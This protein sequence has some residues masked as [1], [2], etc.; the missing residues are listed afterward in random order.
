[1]VKKVVV[2]NKHKIRP[3]SSSRSSSTAHTKFI[4]GKYDRA[5]HYVKMRDTM[6][7]IRHENDSAGER[8]WQAA[9]NLFTVNKGLSDG[10]DTAFNKRPPNTLKSK[11]LMQSYIEEGTV[12]DHHLLHA[13]ITVRHGERCCHCGPACTGSRVKMFHRLESHR[14]QGGLRILL[15][16]DLLI[17]ILEI[18]YKYRVGFSILAVL[19]QMLRQNIHLHMVFAVK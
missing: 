18:L 15:L 5:K 4:R 14:F 16:V 12:Q 7:Q 2:N 6:K 1:M 8:F 19:I 11:K 3:S 10:K 17:V 13:G 9:T